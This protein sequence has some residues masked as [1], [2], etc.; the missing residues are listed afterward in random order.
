MVGRSVDQL[1]PV[2]RDFWKEN[3]FTFSQ[4]NQILGLLETEWA[5]NRAKL[6]QD[7][8]R[9][10]LGK[11]LDGLYSTGERDKYRTQLEPITPQSTEIRISTAA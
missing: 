1:F 8:I 5:E 7:L 9:R 3:G 10:T 11:V 6:P 4:E 2:V